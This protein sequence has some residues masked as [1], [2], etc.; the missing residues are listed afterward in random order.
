MTLPPFSALI[1]FD[2]AARHGTF[3]KAAQE[4]NVSQP[5]ISRRV[6]MLERDLGC[7]LFDRT[8]KPM[9]LT[10][11]GARLFETLRMGL[12]R[13]ELVVEEI[14]GETGSKTISISASSGF[15][16]FWLIPRLSELR[17][18]FPTIVA[19]VINEDTEAKRPIS[20][21]QIRFGDGN[22]PETTNQKILGEHVFPVASPLYLKQRPLPLS[23]DDLHAEH[24]LQIDV[25][26]KHWH[27]WKSWFAH[28]GVAWKESRQTTKFD[29]YVVM[30]SAALAGQGIC[31][32]WDGLL[33]TFLSSG[34]LVRVAPESVR[35]N[36]GYHITHLPDLPEESVIRQVAQWLSDAAEKDFGGREG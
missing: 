18:R 27:D 10:E 33:D 34:A 12:S 5:A 28:H 15:A 3:T 20:D 32:C 16:S 11:N 7:T 6:A 17:E 21:L 24:L 1:A 29:S 25:G 4:Q 9:A 13:L 30:I 26:L 2:A 22:W 36:R 23:L 8:S 35:S 31:L 14:R 19:R